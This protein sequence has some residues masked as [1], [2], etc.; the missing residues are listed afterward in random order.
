[1]AVT[2]A[3]EAAAA[4]FEA[5]NQVEFDI[6]ESLQRYVIEPSIA[7]PPVGVIGV[8]ETARRL[9]VS[10]ATVYNWIEAV[11]RQLTL[12]VV[13]RILLKTSMVEPLNVRPHPLDFVTVARSACSTRLRISR[14]VASKSSGLTVRRDS[15]SREESVVISEF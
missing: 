12:G 6:P 1:L 7:I 14:R 15:R 5:L 8:D 3:L 13:H 11:L 2:A 10:R 4:Q 9:V